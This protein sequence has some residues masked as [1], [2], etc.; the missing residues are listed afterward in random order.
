MR[1]PGVALAIVFGALAVRSAIHWGR[2]PF[3]SPA[4][5]DHVMYALF[6]VSRVGLWATLAAWFLLTS[7]TQPELADYQ[8]ERASADAARLRF[9][10][11][12]AI[13]LVCAGVQFVT[14]WFLGRR[15]DEAGAAVRSDPDGA[16][17]ER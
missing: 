7:Q 8:A 12:G 15:S 3:A 1:W 2:R 13:F 10:W 11:I 9:W 16:D 5:G 6:V 4:I 14:S 17:G